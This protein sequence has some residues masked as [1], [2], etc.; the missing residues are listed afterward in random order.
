MFNIVLICGDNYSHDTDGWHHYGFWK[1]AL[2]NHPK[3]KLL[4]WYPWSHWREMPTEGVDLYFFLDFRYDLWNLERFE[5]LH[6]R[7]L[8]WWDAFHMMF[9]VVAQVPLVFDKVYISEYVD[10]QHLQLCG[11]NNVEWLPGAFYPELYKPLDIEKE[12]NIGF[13]GQFDDIVVRK[14]TTRKQLMNALAQKFG[15]VFT[16]DIRGPAVNEIYNK[17]RIMVEK[18]IFCNIGTRLFETVGSGGFTLINKYPCCNG[19][20]QLGLDGTH[21][22]TYDESLDDAEKKIEYYLNNE[23]E[24]NRI[25]KTGCEYFLNH[26]TYKHRLDKILR[27][28]NVKS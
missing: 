4:H 3:I 8:Y 23:E 28:F 15:G 7:I 10:A 2:E 27:D 5:K 17:S 12:N 21:F 6:P 24:R 1:R 13:V 11:F 14:S 19:L 26:H 9:S 25:A 18:T 22:V 20:D 16:K